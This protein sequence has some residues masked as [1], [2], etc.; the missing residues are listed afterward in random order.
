MEIAYGYYENMAGILYCL[1]LVKA[2]DK[3]Q[4]LGKQISPSLQSGW[5]VWDEYETKEGGL[6]DMKTL[7]YHLEIYDKQQE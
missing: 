7:C 3:Y 2:G 1:K 5:S 4:L 6:E